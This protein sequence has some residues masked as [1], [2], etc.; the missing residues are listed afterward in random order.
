MCR[1]DDDDDEQAD[2]DDDDD[3]HHHVDDDDQAWCCSSPV[4]QSVD[5][6]GASFTNVPQMVQNS[7]PLNYKYTN[8]K[9]QIY[10]YKLINQKCGFKQCWTINTNTD[11]L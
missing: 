2:Q 4:T 10:K 9:I 11:K 6:A 8:T 7:T 5:S 1:S 3:H